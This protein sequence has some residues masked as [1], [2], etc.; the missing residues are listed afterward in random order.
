[1]SKLRTAVS[2]VT[3]FS[4]MRFSVRVFISSTTFPLLTK[5]RTAARFEEIGEGGGDLVRLGRAAA[6]RYVSFWL[7][8]FFLSGSFFGVHKC[9]HRR[10]DLRTALA[11]F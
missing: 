2:R 5:M 1:M 7:Y 6:S 3:C 4:V 11:N 10:I 9:N 8:T